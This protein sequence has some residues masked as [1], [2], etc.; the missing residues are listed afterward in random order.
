MP[1]LSVAAGIA[2]FSVMDAT[3]KSASIQAGVYNA[4]LLRA[5]I[6]S[7]LVLPL[8]LLAGG[9]CALRS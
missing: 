9:R 1:F 7:L 4:M 2:T 3:M 6:G 5:G 8:W